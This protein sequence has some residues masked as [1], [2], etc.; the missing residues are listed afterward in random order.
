MFAFVVQIN[1]YE[2][3]VIEIVKPDLEYPSHENEL[4]AMHH[5]PQFVEIIELEYRRGIV[6]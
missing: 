1:T 4:I 3:R 6:S 5:V 2:V